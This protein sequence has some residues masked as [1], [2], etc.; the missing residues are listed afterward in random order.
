MSTGTVNASDLRAELP[1]AYDEAVSRAK[2]ALKE[3]G[4]GVLSEIH[5]DQALREKLNVEFRKYVILGAC[6]P[7]LAYQALNQEIE[8]G[9]R[10]PC[11]VIVYEEGGHSVVSAMDPV[12][13]LQSVE[14]AGL[15]PIAQQAREKLV[16]A[17]AS[18]RSAASMGAREAK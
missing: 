10:L 1:L 2:A 16:S 3:Q 8:I 5:V 17:V 9:L 12:L 15:G 7:K 11:N 4:F 18:L 13:A 14:G 6:N